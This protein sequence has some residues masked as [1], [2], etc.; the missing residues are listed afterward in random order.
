MN[1]AAPKRIYRQKARAESTVA[2][3]ARILDA[4]AGQLRERWFDEIRL[5]DVAREANVTVQ[6]VIRRFGSKEGLL[7]ATQQRFGEQV[8]RRRDVAAGD[9]A[10]AV[11]S[12]V[13]DYEQAGDLVLRTLAQED[14]HPAIRAMTDVGRASHR[15]W[16]SRAFE[17]WLGSLDREARR[18]AADALVV[19]GDVYVWK[20]IRRDMERPVNEYRQL[21]ESLCA[22][23]VGV[24]REQIFPKSDRREME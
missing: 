18:K 15:Q 19:A 16:I 6:T 21:V 23:A 14:R 17:P 3:A 13:V 10:G 5:E 2:N 7:E 24:P 8:R 9:A 20:L 1:M 22:A 12:L 4:F 11:A